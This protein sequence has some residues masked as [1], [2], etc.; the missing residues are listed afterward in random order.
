[1]FGEEL[2][3]LEQVELTLELTH[4]LK[5]EERYGPIVIP[6]TESQMISIPV[7]IPIENTKAHIEDWWGLRPEMP[8]VHDY[9]SEGRITQIAICAGYIEVELE[10]PSLSQWTI[11][12]NAEQV[13]EQVEIHVDPEMPLPPGMEDIKERLIRSMFGAS[14]SFAVNEALQGAT[15]NYKDGTSDVIDEI[16][17]VIAGIWSQGSGITPD[18][19]YEGKRRYQFT[20]KQAFDLSAVDSLTIDGTK[21]YFHNYGEIDS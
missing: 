3:E 2:R 15:V 6:V 5:P 17:R 4:N 9:V 7:D 16:S 12:S 11:E 13:A 18:S 19:V 10:T 21:Y 8:D 14:W 1:M 20:P